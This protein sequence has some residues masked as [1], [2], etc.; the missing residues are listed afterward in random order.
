M[1]ITQDMLTR[2][3]SYIN[4]GHRAGFYYEYYKES[5]PDQTL[6]QAS[7]TSYSGAIGGMALVRV[8]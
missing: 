7:K 2:W 5:G 1:A 3:Q 6:L 4:S 8:G